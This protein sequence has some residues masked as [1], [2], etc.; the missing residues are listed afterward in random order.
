[1]VDQHASY[2]FL[3]RGIYYYS[4]RIPSDLRSHY[5]TERIVFSLRTTCSNT[6]ITLAARQTAD[7]SKSK[8]IVAFTSS[9]GTV[10]R[11]SK[12]RPTV[13]IIAGCYNIKV[14]RQLAIA[15][16]VYPIVLAPHKEGKDFFENFTM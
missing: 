8:A 6:A 16:G 13:P 2:I 9:G 5:K 3:K 1:M 7:I 14:A 12:L 15:W 11:V 10:M 4:R